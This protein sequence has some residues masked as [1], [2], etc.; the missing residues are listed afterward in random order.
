M[1]STEFGIDVETRGNI[2][3]AMRMEMEFKKDR[4]RAKSNFTR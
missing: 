4:A 1:E 3:D 2:V